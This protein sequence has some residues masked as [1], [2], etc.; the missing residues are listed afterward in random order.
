MMIMIYG[1]IHYTVI[2]TW[3]SKYIVK[4]FSP[5]LPWTSCNH[6]WNTENCVDSKTL[7]NN[8]FTQFQDNF[9]QF[10]LTF[11]PNIEMSGA[12]MNLNGSI[13]TVKRL[14]PASEEFLK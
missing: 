14:V 10:N 5:V 13:D 7:Q 6:T 4:S 12:G 3:I 2:F 9:T 8:N 11:E 1:N